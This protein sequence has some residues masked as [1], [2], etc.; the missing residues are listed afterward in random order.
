MALDN[1]GVLGGLVGRLFISI[2]NAGLYALIGT[3]IDQSN[4]SLQQ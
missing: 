2:A 3:V 1:A 4:R